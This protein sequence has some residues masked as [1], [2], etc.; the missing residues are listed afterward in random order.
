MSRHLIAQAWDTVTVRSIF[1]CEK[2]RATNLPL[3]TS[4]PPTVA[5]PNIFKEEMINS[6][7]PPLA[8]PMA[9]GNSGGRDGTCATARTLPD[10]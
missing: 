2:V 5:L 10:P 7:F 4:F 8:I 1:L 3:N 6:F 9:C